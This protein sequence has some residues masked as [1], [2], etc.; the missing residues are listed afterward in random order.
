MYVLINEDRFDREYIHKYAFGFE[1]L[2]AHV[3]QY[4]PEWAYTQTGIKPEVIR[5][6]AHVISESRPSSLIHPGRRVNWYG[7]D[8]QRTRAIAILSALLGSWGRKGGYI[9]PENVKV[10]GL[11]YPKS[12]HENEDFGFPFADQPLTTEIR[13]KS[14]GDESQIKAWFIYGTNLVNNMPDKAKTI[15]ALKQ[16]DFVV[17]VDILPAEITGWADQKLIA[18]T[19]KPMGAPSVVKYGRQAEDSAE[20]ATRAAV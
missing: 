17:A 4:S 5:E 13:N 18:R 9:V 19:L 2:K 3:Q 11:P 20:Y 15:E 1:Q 6:T 16:L 8:T 14:L 10:K 7:N 12:E